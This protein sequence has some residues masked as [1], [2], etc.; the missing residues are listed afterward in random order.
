MIVDK[1]KIKNYRSIESLDLVFQKDIN[2]FVGING[3]GKTTI[4]DSIA[5][6]LS[7]LTNRLQKENKVG[8]T[9]SES[10]IRENTLT[11]S[12]EIEVSLPD[13]KFRWKLIQN[14]K[15]TQ[16][17]EKSNFADISKLA[18]CL[19]NN[20][21][22]N[23]PIIAYY[24]INRIVRNISPEIISKKNFNELDIYADITAVKVNFKAFFEWFRIQDDILNEEFGSRPKW[25]N[26]N[27]KWL[28]KKLLKSVSL[29]IEIVLE[30]NEFDYWLNIIHSESIIFE[31]YRILFRL[32]GN[33]IDTLDISNEYKINIE[34]ILYDIEYLVHEVDYL[35]RDELDPIFKKDKDP[36]KTYEKIFEKIAVFF[37]KSI[38]IRLRRILV[39]FLWD[40]LE[41]SLFLGF[42]W[43]TIKGKKEIENIFRDYKSL[44]F[45]KNKNFNDINFLDFCNRLDQ[46]IKNDANRQVN[47]TKNHGRELQIIS[48]TIENFIDG[49]KN[50]RIKRT[51]RPH[52]LVDK[53]GIPFNLEQLSDG[54]KN[55]IALIGDITRR[56]CIA[57]PNLENPLTGSGIIL[58]DEIDL[59]L[60]PSWQRLI[61]PKLKDNFPNCQFFISTHS[62]QVLNHVEAEKIFLLH[63]ENNILTCIRPEQSY[64]LTIDR[65]MTLLMNQDIRPDGIKNK[66]DNLYEL[67]ERHELNKAKKIL[68]DLKKYLKNDPEILRAELLIKKET[69]KK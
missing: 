7:W 61:I 26:D 35:Y 31:N 41:I 25:L 57:N 23:K 45:Q 39:A 37:N 55:L 1:I 63:N 13:D 49:Y 21:K 65:I 51:P 27:K 17:K 40:I 5:N 29:L 53:M 19:I 24:P 67:I 47:I 46:V 3:S 16:K 15:G 22:K 8:R 66:I 59:H 9:I 14:K 42:W 68:S 54:E 44:I 28:Q 36:Y 10:D 52:M 38:E 6:L 11:S 4:L 60:H 18:N 32:I 64:G 43:V 48:S 58:I 30:K 12:L 62:P 2:V 33:F 34:K 56:L 50:L 69:L 20:Y